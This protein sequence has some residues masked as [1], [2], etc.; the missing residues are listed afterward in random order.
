MS[1]MCQ[2]CDYTELL[3]H[4]RLG[5]TP[6][7]IAVLRTIGNAP[8]PMAA[9]EILERLRGRTPMNKVTLYRILDLLVDRGMISRLSGG[10]RSFRYGMGSTVH[11]PE[12]P[13]LLSHEC[14]ELECLAPDL[15]PRIK[16]KS[17]IKGK[18]LIQS[19]DIR[20]QGICEKCLN[21]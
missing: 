6:R 7:R 16:K 9:P 12:H 11:H 4:Y 19:L 14:G 2:Q 17:F 3:R 18:G 8:R 1:G 13:H 21:T 20:Y 5:P 15:L 10:D